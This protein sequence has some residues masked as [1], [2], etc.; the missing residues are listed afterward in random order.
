[1]NKKLIFGR[2]TE[3]KGHGFIRKGI[4]GA[5]SG[6]AIAG[7]LLF[8]GHPNNVLADEQTSTNTSLNNTDNVATTNNIVTTDTIVNAVSD[9]TTA[10]ND[11]VSEEV[12]NQI[13]TDSINNA[14]A[15]KVEE[16]NNVEKSPVEDARGDNATEKE[17]AENTQVQG[18]ELDDSAEMAT[19]AEQSDIVVNSD[20][21]AKAIEEAKK[22]GVSIRQTAPD[23]QGVATTPEEAE[24]MEKAI[25]E[26]YAN[27]IKELREKT[28]EALENQKKTADALAELDAH[29]NDVGYLSKTETQSLIF[30]SEPDAKHTVSKEPSAWEDIK[31]VEK[32]MRPE[33]VTGL[34]N[35]TNKQYIISTGESISVTYTNLK[36]SSLDGIKIGKVVYTYTLNYSGYGNSVVLGFCDDPTLTL[37]YLNGDKDFNLNMDVKFYDE[38]G[39]ELDPD[40]CLVSFASL[41]KGG[42]SGDWEGVSDFS[43][44]LIAINGSSIAVQSD[45]VARSAGSNSYKS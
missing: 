28:A 20:E 13:D 22:A 24:K 19:D 15:D 10:N 4:K 9:A 26:Y 2:I 8:A 30:Q 27:L 37:W 44:E 32:G 45:G 6:I 5:I 36:N 14:S 42:S 7:A 39:N 3:G 25:Q 11:T 34:N 40:G 16:T 33:T 31:K 18:E 41:N 1:M 29:K 21:L 12:K 43:G 17:T 35:S 23:N 38:D